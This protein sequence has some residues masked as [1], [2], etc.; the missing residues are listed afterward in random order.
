MCYV[1]A[2][3]AVYLKIEVDSGFFDRLAKLSFIFG[4]LIRGEI[5]LLTAE[6]VFFSIDISTQLLHVTFGYNSLSVEKYYV[7][8]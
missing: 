7:H 6:Q 2:D 8:S 5:Y 1:I 3:I 4:N